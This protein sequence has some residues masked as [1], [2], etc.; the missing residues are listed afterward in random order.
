MSLP[1]LTECLGTKVYGKQAE[2]YLEYMKKQDSLPLEERC[3]DK[4]R[5]EI[6]PEFFEKFTK[7]K[8]LK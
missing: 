3:K 5:F 7:L 4:L 1:K 2:D 6:K 8:L